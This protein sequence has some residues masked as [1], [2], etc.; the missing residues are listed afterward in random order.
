MAAPAAVAA[1]VVAAASVLTEMP[2]LVQWSLALVAGGGAAGAVHGGTAL[3][4]L[5]S[6]AVTGGLGNPVIATLELAGAVIGSALALLAPFAAA[7]A[8]LLLIVILCGLFKRS[9][10]R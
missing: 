1:G 9:R 5:K 6:T 8:V 2:P 3:L 7:A 10:A 4:R